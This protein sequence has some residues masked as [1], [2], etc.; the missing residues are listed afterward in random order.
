MRATESGPLILECRQRL[1]LLDQHS[2][3]DYSR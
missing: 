2:P 1:F 3:P